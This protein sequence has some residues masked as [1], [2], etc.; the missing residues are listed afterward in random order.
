MGDGF[1]DLLPDAV[2]TRASDAGR[3]KEGSG[4]DLSASDEHLAADSVF[5]AEGVINTLQ[6]L[7]VVLR[8]RAGAVVA[9]N[10]VE[11]ALRG[12]VQCFVD[13]GLKGIERFA[14]CGVF[15]SA[16]DAR[17]DPELFGNS[18]NVAVC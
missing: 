1:V 3:P 15:L 16:E 2:L 18:A 7:P 12:V 6:H 4:C 13:F 14:S 10:A 17:S 5:V 9:Q 8:Q 11:M